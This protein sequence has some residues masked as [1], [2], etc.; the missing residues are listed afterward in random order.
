MV[1]IFDLKF[2]RHQD[3][4]NDPHDLLPIVSIRGIEHPH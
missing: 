2:G 3:F 4:F 1:G